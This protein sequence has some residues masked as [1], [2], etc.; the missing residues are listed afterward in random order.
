VGRYKAYWSACPENKSFAMLR[1]YAVF[2][3]LSI[4]VAIGAWLSGNMAAR[5]LHVAMPPGW[6]WLLPLATLFVYNLDHQVD[7][8]R[9]GEKAVTAR[10]RFHVY[11]RRPVRAGL[12]VLFG[13]C[14]SGLW[15]PAPIVW[16]GVGLAAFTVLHLWLVQWAGSRASALL[17]KELGVA[18]VY[19]AGIWLPVLALRGRWP[20]GLE[21]AVMAAFFALVLMSLVLFSCYDVEADQQ[22]GQTSLVQ[23]WGRR[24]SVAFALLLG[25]GAVLGAGGV[26]SMYPSVALAYLLTAALQTWLLLD[27]RRFA[28]NERYRL[29]GELVFWLPGIVI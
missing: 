28:P 19:A 23:G 5:V 24:A 21:W 20:S 3:H 26:Y 7:A 12:V 29:I 16:A 2:Q 13:L 25:A 15:L 18:L 22:Q 17:V 8:E 1:R 11:W 27:Q 10:H 9:V 6:Q 14:L 4:D